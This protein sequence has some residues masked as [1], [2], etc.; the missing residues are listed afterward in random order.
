MVNIVTALGAGS[1]IDVKALAQSLV[2][3]E[4]TPRKER[5]DV[6]IKQSEARISGHG[7]IKYALSQL[8]DA[9]A[10]INDASDFASIK[11][12]N[13]QP[14]AFGVT[15]NSKA[16][17][18]NFSL[19]VQQI[20]QAQRS[21]SGSFAAQDTPLSAG[22]DLNLA[23]ET[24]ISPSTTTSTIPVTNKTPAGIVSAINGAGKGISAQLIN[25]GSEYKIVITGEAGAAKAFSLTSSS[26]DVSFGSTPTQ[27]AQDARFS[28]NGLSISRPT[29]TISDVVDGVT[30]DLYTPT[31]TP[32]RLDLQRETGSIKENLQGLVT[33]Y[34]DFEASMKILAD[35]ASKVEEYGGALANDSLLQSVRSQVRAMVTGEKKIYASTDTAQSNPL[36]PD[37]YAGRQVGLSIDRNGVMSLDES[38]LDKAL[39]GHFDQVVTLF[40]AGQSGQSV[41][42]TVDGGLAGDAV[43]KLDKMMRSTGAIEA[44]TKSA[45][46]QI[47]RYKSE[48]TK[49]EERMTKL[50]ERYTQQF[51]LMESIVGNSNSMKT[52]LKNTFAAMSGTSNN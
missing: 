38:K 22:S 37:V 36:N 24:G 41:Y 5:I 48:L 43:K 44:Q 6:K 16:Q 11:P 49:L 21:V 10:K 40:S 27:S 52:S 8:K 28:L 31:T 1:G 32:A 15:A 17:A 3:A 51:S 20:A 33:A 34:N 2:D 19:E 50:L 47:T 23:L 18:G 14:T 12:T 25:T 30:L 46:Q 35:P 39:S 45:N 9:F 29:N 4:K 13:S 42:S 7:A 26:G